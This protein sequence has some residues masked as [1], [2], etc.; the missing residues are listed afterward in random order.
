MAD[1]LNGYES[2]CEDEDQA[3]QELIP[4]G[5]MDEAVREALLSVLI[6]E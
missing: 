1:I 4:F 6:V 3:S 2:D 5:Q